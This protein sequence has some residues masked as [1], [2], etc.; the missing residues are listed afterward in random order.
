MLSRPIL[1]R[2]I[3]LIEYAWDVAAESQAPTSALPIGVSRTVSDTEL[4]AVDLTL[5]K[6]PSQLLNRILALSQAEDD[7]GDDAIVGSP[8]LGFVYVFVFRPL[9]SVRARVGIDFGNNQIGNRRGEKE[10]H[11]TFSATRPIA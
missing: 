7:A 3:N 6:T 4:L 10:S 2:L 11:H 1:S 5:P 8:I 9:S